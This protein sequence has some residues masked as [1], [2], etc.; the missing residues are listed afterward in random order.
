LVETAVPAESEAAS[1]ATLA[2]LALRLGSEFVIAFPFPV[3]V[4][5]VIGFLNLFEPLRRLRRLVEVG[6]PLLG[7]LSVSRFYLI[8]GRMA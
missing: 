7:E 2:L 8:L 3:V 1:V 4:E 6:V 5:R